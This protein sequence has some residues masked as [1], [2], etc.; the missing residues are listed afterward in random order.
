VSGD[1]F[2]ARFGRGVDGRVL[3]TGSPLVTAVVPV[4]TH[5]E[6]KSAQ[7]RVASGRHG[8]WLSR[9]EHERLLAAGG[10]CVLGVRDAGRLDAGRGRR[11]RPRM[12]VPPGHV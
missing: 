6:I 3:P 1:R 11:D 12:Y 4:G 10:V 9:Q 5:G 2:D 7:C 8:R